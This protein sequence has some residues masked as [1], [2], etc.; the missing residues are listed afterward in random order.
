MGFEK[1][2][3]KFIPTKKNKLARDFLKNFKI[4][5]KNL[6][7][8]EINENTTIFELN[9]ENLS[10]KKIDKKFIKISKMS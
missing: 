6:K 1:L 3:G 8:S 9:M 2:S 7:N 10:D 5:G 4:F